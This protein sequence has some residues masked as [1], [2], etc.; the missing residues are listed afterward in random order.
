[1]RE[2]ITT[3]PHVAGAAIPTALATV[4]Y[5]ALAVHPGAAVGL[6]MAPLLVVAAVALFAVVLLY[7]GEIGPRGR[8]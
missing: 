7:A 6:D 2:R 3:H 1:M 5:A 8:L 4:G